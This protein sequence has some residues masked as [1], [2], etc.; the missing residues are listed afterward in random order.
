M[1]LPDLHVFLRYRLR[2]IWPGLPS[3]WVGLR[4]SVGDA[5]VDVARLT[6]GSVLAYMLTV[7]LLPP[8]VDLTGALTAL[9]VI[10]ASLRGSFQMLSLIH[11]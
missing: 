11:I 7:W 8:P 10:Q 9:L 5:A 6:T 2:K 4:R 3:T 1:K